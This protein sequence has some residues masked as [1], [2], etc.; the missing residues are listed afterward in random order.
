[1]KDRGHRAYVNVDMRK[2]IAKAKVTLPENG[3]P[4]E[5]LRELPHDNHI[6]KLAMQKHAT[7]VP[8]P[9]SDLEKIKEQ[10]RTGIPNAVTMEKSSMDCVDYNTMFHNALDNLKQKIRKT[11]ATA[12][13]DDKQSYFARVANS[14]ETENRRQKDKT[15]DIRQYFTA[16]SERD[17][18][19]ALSSVV[20]M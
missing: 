19:L 4:P 11:E 7:T 5:V 2:V 12:G 18:I 15:I 16:A 17:N 3:V 6:D 20:S 10:L 13:A 1:M 8:E 9:T 14:R